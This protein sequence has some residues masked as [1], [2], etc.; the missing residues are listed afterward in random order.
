M[1]PGHLTT[2]KMFHVSHEVRPKVII[3]KRPKNPCDKNQTLKISKWDHVKFL[4]KSL[5]LVGPLGVTQLPLED[6]G[7]LLN[8]I[9]HNTTSPPLARGQSQLNLFLI[10]QNICLPWQGCQNIE[11]TGVKVKGKPL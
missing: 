7:C 11:N 10:F 3:R 1:N 6:D 8:V 9:P 4:T 5:G 2:N